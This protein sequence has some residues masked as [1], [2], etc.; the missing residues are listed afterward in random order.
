MYEPEQ[1]VKRAW[2]DALRGRD[3]SRFGFVAIAQGVL[4]KILPHSLVMNVWQRQQK[5]K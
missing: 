5:L 1:I 3:I 2:R 4:A